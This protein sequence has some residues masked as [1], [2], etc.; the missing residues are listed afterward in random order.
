M[1]RLSKFKKFISEVTPPDGAKARSWCH[2]VT[3]RRPNLFSS[4]D[5]EA[6]AARVSCSNSPIEGCD[7]CIGKIEFAFKLI[8]EL[9][10][11]TLTDPTLTSR[12]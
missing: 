3:I 1:S 9:N 11:V 8:K 7:T 12:K 2:Y 5:V 6:L 10:H 4:E